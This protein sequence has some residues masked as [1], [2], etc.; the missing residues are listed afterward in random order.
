MSGIISFPP[1]AGG[2]TAV[3]DTYTNTTPVPTTIGG[4]PSGAT[5]ASKTMKDMWDMLLYPYQTPTFSAFGSSMPTTLEIGDS[6]A[7]GAKSFSWST[8]NSANLTAN[9]IIIKQGGTAIGSALAND[10]SENLSVTAITSNTIA[11]FTFSIEATNTKNAT[12]SRTLTV[13]FKAP[14]WYGESALAT[15]TGTDVVAL[16][17]KNLATS[18]NG[19]YAMQE[20]GYKWICYPKS[21]GLKNN[22]KDVA[23]NFDVAMNPV[24]TVSVTNSF[25]VTQDYYCHRTYNVLGSGINIGVS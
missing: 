24:E 23:T 1:P 21:L 13:S 11:N 5:F 18:P 7:A 17:A 4:V 2:G 9:S 6:I 14:V 20:G 16:R 12:L 3:A 19:N 15:L 25:G 8:T 10:G 22:F